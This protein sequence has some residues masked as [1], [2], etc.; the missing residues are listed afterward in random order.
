MH[1]LPCR[2]NGRLIQRHK[3][4]GVNTEELHLNTFQEIA[5][6]R[7]TVDTR[8]FGFQPD[9]SPAPTEIYRD[10]GDLELNLYE[11]SEIGK[12]VSP[13]IKQGFEL[14]FWGPG[15]AVLGSGGHLLYNSVV[16][17]IFV[18][19]NPVSSPPPTE[20]DDSAVVYQCLFQ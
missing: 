9:G 7:F 3:I 12:P 19:L 18:F 15:N 20:A 2:L 6:K 17:S 8:Y 5:S 10:Y 16:G 13:A 11:V 14:L 1:R 4:M